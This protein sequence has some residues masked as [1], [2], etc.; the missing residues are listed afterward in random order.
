MFYIYIYVICSATKTKRQNGKTP[1]QLPWTFHR[2]NKQLLEVRTP[3]RGIWQHT[4][5]TKRLID[6][7]L[8]CLD[9]QPMGNFPLNGGFGCTPPNLQKLH[10]LMMFQLGKAMVCWAA[11]FYETSISSFFTLSDMKIKRLIKGID[12]FMDCGNED[13]YRWRLFVNTKCDTKNQSG[14]ILSACR[15][16]QIQHVCYLKYAAGI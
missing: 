15:C 6:V 10:C 7:H 5:K 16:I 12:E 9:S 14:D 11:P 2:T 3:Q 1:P 13:M 8:R 4:K